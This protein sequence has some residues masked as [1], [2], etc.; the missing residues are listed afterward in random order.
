MGVGLRA[1]VLRAPELLGAALVTGLAAGLGA[2]LAAAC[3][4][5]PPSIF[6]HVG[7]GAF[8]G[9][10]A[11]VDCGMNQHLWCAVRGAQGLPNKHYAPNI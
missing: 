4:D 10:F 8:A 3:F 2:G 9:F 7:P 11:A 1:D 5:L 6:D